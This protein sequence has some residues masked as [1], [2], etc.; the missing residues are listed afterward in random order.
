MTIS[1]FES[2]HVFESLYSKLHK[3]YNWLLL[4]QMHVGVIWTLCYMGIEI[5]VHFENFLQIFSHVV[6]R[7]TFKILHW[8]F[9]SK[10]REMSS[11]WKAA[12]S[13]SVD[14]VPSRLLTQTWWFNAGNDEKTGRNY[15]NFTVVTQTGWVETVDL[16]PKTY[17]SDHW[18]CNNISNFD[19]M[20]FLNTNW[21]TF[22]RWVVTLSC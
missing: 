2:F 12:N 15:C 9:S 11:S 7:P 16:G 3:F 13:T 17:G 18:P 6:K 22:M 19:L 5:K 14:N 20:L 8:S 4:K 21:G 10:S 1:R